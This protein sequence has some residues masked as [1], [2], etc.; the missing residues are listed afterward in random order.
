MNRA[1]RRKTTWAGC[2]ALGL[3]GL[4]CGL[5]AGEKPRDV[6]SRHQLFI[7]DWVTESMKGCVRVLHQP[8]RDANNPVVGRDHPWETWGSDAKGVTYTP[9]DGLFRMWYRSIGRYD[10]DLYGDRKAEFLTGFATSRDGVHWEKPTLERVDFRGSK[11]NN[12]IPNIGGMFHDTHEQNPAR[13]F[14]V[15]GQY[16]K[17][18]ITWSRDPEIVAPPDKPRWGA[19][20]YVDHLEKYLLCSQAGF[21]RQAWVRF[22]SDLK[23]WTPGV[24]AVHGDDQDPP[25]MEVYVMG[26]ACRDGL[27]LGFPAMYWTWPKPDTKRPQQSGWI[28][29]Q[30]ATSRDGVHWQRA[31]D[32]QTFFRRGDDGEF[33]DAMVF[34]L[35]PIE[36]NNELLFFY[37][38]WDDHHG[39][40]VRH[41]ATGLARLRRDGYISL[42]P[43]DDLTV[44]EVT[45]KPLKFE[46]SRLLV[47]A[48]ADQ[49]LGVELLDGAGK[50][51]PG[52]ERANCSP[53]KGDKLD[54][55][56]TWKGGKSVGALAAK[57]V[58]VRFYLKRA[59]LYAFR[60]AN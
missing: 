60:F 20:T 45:T 13:R 44:A 34:L 10:P 43:Y 40:K 9:D 41:S 25:N 8:V 53:I 50:P 26:L 58:K 29:V 39:T 3:L 52:F 17:D 48:V 23:T 54:H 42:V 36:F 47:N 5:L 7:D 27:I 30:L 14:K 22:S 2:L 28:D 11:K 59:H 33:D 57:P 6:G 24:R 4:P 19:V 38:G 12:L 21:P 18:G 31:G 51:I 1:N 37:D 35:P 55:V 46:G 56:V 16:S 32:R 15:P 49:S